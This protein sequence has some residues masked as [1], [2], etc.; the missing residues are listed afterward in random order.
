[1]TQHNQS[2]LVC[3]IT[4]VGFHNLR[5][6]RSKSVAEARSEGRAHTDMNAGGVGV[7]VREPLK[8]RVV[9]KPEV[10]PE[11]CRGSIADSD[12]GNGTENLEPR[13]NILPDG[14][15][16]VMAIAEVTRWS[17]A[18]HAAKPAGPRGSGVRVKFGEEL[19]EK[20]RILIAN[21]DNSKPPAS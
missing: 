3:K 11:G 12:P 4:E 15:I 13:D 16:E 2:Q 17:P 6:A 9:S 14:G 10:S 1:M 18:V 20:G 21:R 19:G 5:K 8:E 7:K